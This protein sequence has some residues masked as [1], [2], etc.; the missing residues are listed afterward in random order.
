MK[1][2]PEKKL[3]KELNLTDRFLFDE[4]IEDPQTH[5]DIL[6]II[7][8]RE[9]PLLT[10]NETEKEMR[11]S[12]QIR[13]VRMDVFS[14]DEERT[15]YNTEMQDKRKSDLA[16]RSRYYQALLDTNLLEPGIPNYNLLNTSYIILITTFDLFG[17]GKYQY[18]FEARCRE[19]PGCVLE[20]QAVRIFLNTRGKNDSE[21]S[22]ELVSFLHYI[23]NTT[24]AVA[25]NS[26]SE[27]IKRIH[28][29]V[30]KVKVSEE[31]G[32]K[33]MQAWE[34]KY[35]EREEGREEGAKAKLQELIRKKL[36]KGKSVEKI[37]DE[38]EESIE[39]IEK[40]IEEM[41]E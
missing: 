4:V 15:V 25:E 7:F 31:I 38:L 24:D 14:M 16:K 37:A 26:G 8:G 29:R 22:E 28:N 1:E 23:E 34:E 30:R 40:I 18:T 2:K 41:E 9:I 19:E 36:V 27:R 13:S 12:P 20:D 11:V 10:K 17:Y 32:V 3:L 6:S 21:V 5:Q 39:T 35:Y 33:Y